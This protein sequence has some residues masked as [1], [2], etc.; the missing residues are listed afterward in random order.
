[1]STEVTDVSTGSN[2]APAE[3]PITPE[4]NTFAELM[5]TWTPEQRKEWDK[6]GKEPEPAVTPVVT[7]TPEPAKAKTV[8]EAGSGEEDQDEEPEY[9]GTAEQQKKQRHAFARQKRMNAEL[10]GEL[11]ILREQGLREQR[12]SQPAANVPAPKAEP[13]LTP[14]RPKRPRINDPKYAEDANGVKYDV[15]MDEYEKAVRKFDRDET[16]RERALEASKSERSEKASTWKAEQELARTAHSDFDQVV[17]ND[18]FIVSLPMYGVLSSMKGG[19]E[20][21]Y[22]LG[23]NPE[24]ALELMKLTD[25]PGTFQTYDEL[26]E[27][28]DADPKLAKLLG[29]AEG[30]VRAEARRILASLNVANGSANGAANNNGSK[31]PDSKPVTITRVPPPGARVDSSS[32]AA[33]NPIDEAWAQYDKTGDHKYL[34]LANDLE[35][36]R[37]KEKQQRR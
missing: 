33:K 29:T 18:K 4:P 36:K 27:A 24:L 19:G 2:V 31:P 11:K 17:Y 22:Y 15:D 20:A 30:I 16:A 6:S 37:D 32:S 23:S 35:D 9:F 5:K 7:P 1:M 13:A 25:I 26:A 34:K 12:T 21:F 3:T 14:E 10:R 8:P 28:A